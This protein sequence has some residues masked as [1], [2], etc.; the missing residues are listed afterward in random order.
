M[1][2]TLFELECLCCYIAFMMGYQ[3]DLMGKMIFLHC[4]FPQGMC[5]SVF[6]HPVSLVLSLLCHVQV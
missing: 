5:C 3:V 6:T 1:A 4:S 2:E